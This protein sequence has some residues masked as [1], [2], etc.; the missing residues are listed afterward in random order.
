MGFL[1]FPYMRC[2]WGSA[3]RPFVSPELRYNWWVRE[4]FFAV[5]SGLKESGTDLLTT[6]D[7][8]GN[9]GLRDV[10]KGVQ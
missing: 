9:T 1:Q 7:I 6:D 2:L 4:G 8:L 10:T 5:G 3:W